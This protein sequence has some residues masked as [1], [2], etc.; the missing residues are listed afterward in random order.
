M[1]S[2]G[3]GAFESDTALDFL[4]DLDQ[5]IHSTPS[6]ARVLETA[7]AVAQ[8]TLPEDHLASACVPLVKETRSVVDAF[9]DPIFQDKARTV[10]RL[11]AP[12]FFFEAV[13]GSE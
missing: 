6:L 3:A 12:H 11:I 4:G 13:I 5:D 2:W 10:G 7:W 9:H 8:G 1:G